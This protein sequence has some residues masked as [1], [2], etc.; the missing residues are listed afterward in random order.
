MR[1]ELVKPQMQYITK[2]KA[3]SLHVAGVPDIL[4]S[5]DA[6]AYPRR[7]AVNDAGTETE[8]V[9]FAAHPGRAW[10]GLRRTLCQRRIFCW[11]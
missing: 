5:G 11:K 7:S 2:K 8:G 1:S 4:D 6:P 9:E 10:N 3:I